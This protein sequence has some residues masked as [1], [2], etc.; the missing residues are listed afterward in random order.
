M[1]RMELGLLESRAG[2]AAATGGDWRKQNAVRRWGSCSLVFGF[3]VCSRELQKAIN[4][5]GGPVHGNL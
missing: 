1:G 3:R 4:R 5:I 2:A